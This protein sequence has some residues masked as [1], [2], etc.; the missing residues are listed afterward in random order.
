MIQFHPL[1]VKE[2]RLN[3]PISLDMVEDAVILLDKNDFMRTVFIKLE[4]D[5][6]S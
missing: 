5:L 3:R 6:L 1:S 4:K 2:A